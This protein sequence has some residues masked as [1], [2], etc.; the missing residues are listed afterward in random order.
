MNRKVLVAGLAVVVPLIA[1]LLLNLGR[2]PHLI[3]SPL[4]GRPAPPFALVPV[5]GGEAVRLADLRGKP[6]VLNFWATWCV[7]CYQ[8]HPVLASAARSL[9]EEVHFLGVVY[10]DEESNVREYLRRQG[11][12]YPNLMDPD[13]KAAI[14]YGI[15]G[16]PETYF[17]DPGGRI[18][19]KYMGPLDGPTLMARVRQA[20][21]GTP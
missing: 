20:R 11:S 18:V 16:V 15:F 19:T 12:A 2:N 5:E 1:L 13:S 8:E 10:Q 4:I 21:G 7:P 6:V 14:A 17:I 3:D 9:G